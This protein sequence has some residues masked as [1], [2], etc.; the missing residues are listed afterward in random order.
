MNPTGDRRQDAR[1]EEDK[2]VDFRLE[3]IEKAI[4]DFKTTL[5]G[6]GSATG[7]LALIDAR[8]DDNTRRIVLLERNHSAMD[9]TLTEI[10]V[11]LEGVRA[12]VSLAAAIGSLIGAGV[13]A[14]LVKF[15]GG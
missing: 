12:R 1:R 9:N 5:Q 7:H 11:T 3:Q 15:A 6:L 13:V 2:L 14:L 4:D 8:S 10:K